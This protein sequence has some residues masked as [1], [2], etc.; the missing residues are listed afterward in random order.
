M[1]SE[2]WAVQLESALTTGDAEQI[3]RQDVQ[4]KGSVVARIAAVCNS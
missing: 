4:Q 3:S 2:V 1:L